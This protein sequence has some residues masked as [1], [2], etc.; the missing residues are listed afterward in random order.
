MDTEVCVEGP[1]GGASQLAGGQMKSVIVEGFFFF[2][3][4]FTISDTNLMF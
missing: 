4:C 2:K 3:S 1:G